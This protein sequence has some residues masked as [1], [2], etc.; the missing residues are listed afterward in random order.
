MVL[1]GF[2]QKAGVD[3]NLLRTWNGYNEAAKNLNQVLRPEGIEGV[4]LTGAVHSP[5]LWYPYLWM[6]GGEMFQ[7]KSG[8]PTKGVYWFPAFNS[9]LKEL[10][11]WNL[12]NHKLMQA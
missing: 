2:L 1:E 4:H 3:P 11:L 5:D 10:G 7:Q 6:L 9:S 8:H 12:S